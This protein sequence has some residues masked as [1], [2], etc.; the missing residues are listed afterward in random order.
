MASSVVEKFYSMEYGPAP[1]DAG[2]VIKWLEVHKRT[3]GHYIDG[4][5]DQG[6]W[7]DL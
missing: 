2:E 4:A 3:F 5:V 6:F 7:R 1:E